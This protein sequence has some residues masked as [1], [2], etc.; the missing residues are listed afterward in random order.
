VKM[1]RLSSKCGL[2]KVFDSGEVLNIFKILTLDRAKHNHA[3][4]IGQSGMKFEH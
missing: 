2:F 3:K 4:A 1:G